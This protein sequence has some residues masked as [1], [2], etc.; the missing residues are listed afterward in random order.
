[1]AGS[2]SH[3]NGE[4]R[5]GRSRTNAEPLLRFSEAK[6]LMGDIYNDLGEYVNDLANFYNGIETDN[7]Q[8]FVSPSRPSKICWSRQNESRIF[9]RTSNGKSTVINAMLH[10]HVLPTGVGHTTC[11]FLQV[12]GG[13]E[14]ETYFTTEENKEKIPIAELEE[15]GDALHSNN[16]NLSAMGTDSLLKIFYPKANSKLLQNDVVIWIGKFPGIDVS[17]EFDGWIDKHCLDADVFVLV[18]NA[19]STLSNAEKSFFHRVNQKLSRPN[20]F[21]LN[22]RWEISNRENEKR[23]EKLRDQHQTQFTKFLAQE[24]KLCTPEE[25]KDRDL[26][27]KSSQADGFQ[28][29]QMDFIRFENNFEKC[30]SKSAIRT[31]FEAHTRR[32]REIVENMKHNLDSVHNGAM[33]EKQRLALNLELKNQEFLSCRDKFRI[34]EQRYCAEQKRVRA[35]VHL[36]VSADFH[37]EISRLESIF[38]RFKCPFSD[39]PADIDNYK[40]ELAQYAGQTFTS[41]LENL[42]TGGLMARI[43]GLE[44][45]MFNNVKEILGEQYASELDKFW[46][47]NKPFHLLFWSTVLAWCGI[48][49]KILSFDSVWVSSPLLVV[50]SLLLVVSQLQ[51]S[52][53]TL[54]KVFVQS[55]TYLANGSMGIALAGLIV[56]KNVDW[57][58][59]AGGGAVV[60]TMYAFERYRWNS[61]AK[62]ERL[63]DQFRSHLEQ[64]LQ[65]VEHMHTHQCEVQVVNELDKV[66]D[67]LKATVAGIHREMKE[68]IDKTKKSID[69]VDEVV[70]G[71]SSMKGKTNFVSGSLEAFVTKFLSP[72]SPR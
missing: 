42:C 22:N 24:L 6:K 61:G 40:T 63:K 46:R 70:K 12:E 58:W 45:A 56:Y 5:G 35:E 3:I 7:Q 38:D 52:D 2:L 18:C 15:A 10:S 34:F 44:T 50:C 37:E 17:V 21:I 28:L 14:N 32:A 69:K 25:A 39:D 13:S 26:N 19:E 36:K 62:E 53:K 71:L 23:R 66:Y 65:Q 27:G 64:R 30:I 41:D 31:K 1:M 59:L 57:R 8:K 68:N 20:V 55:L 67:G 29:R 11:C 60:G 49:M 16:I 43:W 54:S 33:R 48:F 4:S 72:D 51:L 9:G 47:Y